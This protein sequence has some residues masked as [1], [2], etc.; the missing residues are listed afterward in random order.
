MSDGPVL[1]DNDLIF[2]LAAYCR[3]GYLISGLGPEP[4]QMLPATKFVLKDLAR[5]SRRVTNREAVQAAVEE[6]VAGLAIIS[7]SPEA[8]ALAAQLEE[9]A[10]AHSL[11]LDTGES[12]LL[13]IALMEPVRLILTGDKRAV[14][15]IELLAAVELAGRIA[16]LEQVLAALAER[17]PLD[18][19][20]AAVCSEPRIDTA[21]TMVFGCS[22][23]TC[24][25]EQVSEGL[26]SY[27]E[28]L[29]KNAERCLI[30]NDL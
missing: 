1:A 29:R 19:L 2:K 10:K 6:A 14:A 13:A 20:R 26:A 17:E 22:Q 3:H 8:I 11:E 9:A 4:A 7:P 24:T 30:A 15:A 12:Q 27:I 25:R 5:K 28:H 23:S 16:C 21:A 18:E